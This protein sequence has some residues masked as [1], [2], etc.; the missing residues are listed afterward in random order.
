MSNQE[1]E[2]VAPKEEESTKEEEKSVETEK[3]DSASPQST[4]VG[5]KD[6]PLAEIS[7]DD[8]ISLLEKKFDIVLEAIQAQPK[9]DGK[10]PVVGGGLEA[11][12]PI[13][14]MVMKPEQQEDPAGQLFQE[15][16]KKWTIFSMKK[17]MGIK[18]WDDDN[19]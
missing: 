5:S 6:S 7:A 19:L 3:V 14:Q 17:A 8:R 16:G 15:L 1:E 18:G 9:G 10:T 13:L 11:L 4:D 2:K 12:A